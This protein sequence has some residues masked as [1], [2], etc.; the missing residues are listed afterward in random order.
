MRGGSVDSNCR[1]EITLF[2]ADKV[3]SEAEAGIGTRNE[4]IENLFNDIG[5]SGVLEPRT[6]AD[7]IGSSVEMTGVQQSSMVCLCLPPP[8]S[9]WQLCVSPLQVRPYCKI[10]DL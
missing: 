4:V 5:N 8:T 1:C 9:P 3:A 7:V 2:G 6:C 10:G